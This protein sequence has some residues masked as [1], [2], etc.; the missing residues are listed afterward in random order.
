MSLSANNF[1]FPS[2]DFRPEWLNM[3]GDTELSEAVEAMI[4]RAETLSATLD[5]INYDEDAVTLAETHLVNYFYWNGVSNLLLLAPAKQTTLLRSDEF[6]DTQLR[7]AQNQRDKAFRGV[8]LELSSQI[9][10]SSGYF[11]AVY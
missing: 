5:P 6:T 7:Y 8:P 10:G 11:Q 2:G 3:A 1:M 9:T 4:D